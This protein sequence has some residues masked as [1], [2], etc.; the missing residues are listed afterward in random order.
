[1]TRSLS[2]GAGKKARGADG[3]DRTPAG[4]VRNPSIFSFAD[5]FCDGNAHMARMLVLYLYNQ[6]KVA[7]TRLGACSCDAAQLKTRRAFILPLFLMSV[8]RL[9]P[10]YHSTP[11]DCMYKLSQKS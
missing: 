1:M 9:R 7:S 3:N 4:L 6:E 8:W 10:Y 2:R 11:D 5:D